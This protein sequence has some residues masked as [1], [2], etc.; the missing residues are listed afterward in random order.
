[1][2]SRVIPGSS[3]TIDRRVPVMRLNSVDLPTFGRPQIATSGISAATLDAPS[4]ASINSEAKLSSSRSSRSPCRLPAPPSRSVALGFLLSFASSVSRSCSARSSEPWPRPADESRS[5]R[6]PS[7]LTD[8][9]RSG[10]RFGVLAAFA[11]AAFF[12]LSALRFFGATFAICAPVRGAFP[13]RGRVLAC[14]CF[15][16]I[17]FF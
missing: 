1:M 8:R 15:L 16:P 3:P 12:E 10:L 2:R 17:L 9:S 14:R 4:L 7:S 5:V 13:F 11:S 6:A